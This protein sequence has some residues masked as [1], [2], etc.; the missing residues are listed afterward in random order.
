MENQENKVIVKNDGK[1]MPRLLKMFGITEIAHKGN[2]QF[3][4]MQNGKEVIIHTEPADEDGEQIVL[5][6]VENF[7]SRTQ[8][9]IDFEN[10]LLDLAEGYGIK[11]SEDDPRQARAEWVQEMVGMAKKAYGG[12]D[13]E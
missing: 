11:D 1:E 13:D 3:T 2:Y 4:A 5:L 9:Q 12:G 8:A 10:E 7:D 6:G